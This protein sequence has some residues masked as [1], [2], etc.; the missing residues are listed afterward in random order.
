MLT[1]QLCC[2][3]QQFLSNGCL[4]DNM[5]IMQNWCM[6]STSNTLQMIAK[7]N[8][9]VNMNL[10]KNVTIK[11]HIAYNYV[12]TAFTKNKNMAHNAIIT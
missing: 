6:N 9:S 8:N 12:K 5:T 2:I 4:N 11:L 10:N 3:I 7:C 1:R